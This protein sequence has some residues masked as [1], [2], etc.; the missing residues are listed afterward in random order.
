MVSI[1]V[2]DAKGAC[3]L[4]NVSIPRAGAKVNDASDWWF[5][6]LF[7]ARTLTTVGD[8]FVMCNLSVV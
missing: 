8:G 6:S 3:D 5:M 7:S 4:T 2:F 1:T